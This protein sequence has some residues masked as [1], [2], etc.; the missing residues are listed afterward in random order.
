M[1]PFWIGG[2]IFGVTL[3]LESWYSWR[4][5]KALKNEFPELWAHSGYRDWKT[6][7][8]VTAAWPT[9]KYLWQRKYTERESSQEI[10]FCEY[11][12]PKVVYSW[13]TSIIGV[14]SFFTAWTLFGTPSA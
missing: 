7:S 2:I 12:R 14:C 3:C 11:H 6:D 4:F 8:S 5:L 9:I 13:G 1:H 10:E